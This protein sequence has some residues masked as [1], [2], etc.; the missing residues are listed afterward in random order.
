MCNGRAPVEIGTILHQSPLSSFLFCA[1]G[2]VACTYKLPHKTLTHQTIPSPTRPARYATPLRSQP[3][4]L[5]LTWVVLS[6][7]VFAGD[8]HLK[9]EYFSR[10]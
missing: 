2:M 5:Y 3:A 1:R 6:A 7:F 4:T 8:V 9:S 10:V